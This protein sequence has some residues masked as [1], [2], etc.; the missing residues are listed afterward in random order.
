MSA[1]RIAA[2]A[3]LA[4]AAAFGMAWVSRL[5]VRAN[6]STE[7]VVRL[8]WGARPER[9]EVCRTS[10]DEELEKLPRHMRQRVVCEGTTARYRLEVRRNGALLVD[11]VV[12]GG[13]LRHDRQLYVFREIRVPS[14]PSA[15]DVRFTR[16]DTVR[17]GDEDKR[18]RDEGDEGES[19]EVSSDREIR[20]TEERRRRRGEAVPP[21]LGMSE[22]VVLAPREVLLVTYR[23]E[24]R[25]LVAVRGGR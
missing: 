16:I 22:T 25:R 14:G 7:S 10:T 13:G 6:T 8:A 21:V 12:M 9:V 24:E 3:A 23:P 5:E 11:A 1:I 19:S 17:A 18:D 4:I 15:I 20:E 2:G